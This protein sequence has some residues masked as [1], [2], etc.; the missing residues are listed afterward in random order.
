MTT[1]DLLLSLLVCAAV[2]GTFVWLAIYAVM[3]WQFMRLGAGVP[4]PNPDPV[5]DTLIGA[6]RA[7]FAVGLTI[8]TG[9]LASNTF[10]SGA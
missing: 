8:L 1:A 7:A 4:K 2:V 6:V 10:L 3:A 5:G 9:L